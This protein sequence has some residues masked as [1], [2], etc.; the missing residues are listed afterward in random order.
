MLYVGLGLPLNCKGTLAMA[1]REEMVKRQRVLA[2]FGDFALGCEDLQ[3]ILTEACRLIAD[4][5]DTPLAKV[6]E[7]DREKDRALVRAG[8]GWR[9]GIVGHEYIELDQRS[10]ESFALE[11][12]K[13]VAMQD[14]STEDRF[15]VPGFMKEHG[16]VA[17]INV[18]IFLPGSRPYGLLQV[19]DR[20][21]RK[22]SEEDTE[23]LRTYATILGPVID[24]LHKVSELQEAHDRNATLLRELQHRVKND[25]AVIQA[26]VKLRARRASPEGQAELRV[27]QERLETL[28]LVHAQLDAGKAADRLLLKPYVE[29]L[30]E[31]L[32]T[33]RSHEAA[34]VRL[35]ID[36]DENLEVSRDVAAPLGLI[37]NEFATNSFKYAFDALE[38]VLTVKIEPSGKER[39]KLVARDNG[40]GLGREH[41]NSGTRSGIGL[42]NS[43]SR[44]IGGEA[45]WSSGEGVQLE[46]TFKSR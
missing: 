14:V 19:D 11:A 12:A 24:R 18:P 32:R 17:L 44:Q 5:L 1:D 21:P 13:P 15:D 35:E 33:L 7:I 16:V 36:V 25:L 46:T 23:F 41:A 3:Q 6:L 42:I 2:D 31:N 27:L 22:F 28:R 9:P 34:D 43:L 4:A 38:G 10:S 40:V 29:Q 8:V 37:L 45:R 30:L 20:E 26:L 39:A